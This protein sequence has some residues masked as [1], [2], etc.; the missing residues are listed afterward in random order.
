L[1]FSSQLVGTT[2]VAQDVT[3][4]NTGSSNLTVSDVAAS[5][6]FAATNGCVTASPLI[7]NGTC[8]VSVTFGPVASGART[9]TVT[10]S[11]STGTHIVALTGTGVTPGIGFSPSSVSFGSQVVGTASAPTNI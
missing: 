4:T 1:S 3:L 5:G 9:G 11:D 8:T 10:I 7:P 2:S 6:D